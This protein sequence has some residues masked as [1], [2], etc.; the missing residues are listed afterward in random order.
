MSPL[1]LSIIIPCL[2]EAENIFKT[3]SH[4]Q[5]LRRRGHEVILSDGGSLDDTLK[6]SQS[7]VD[8]CISS[9]AGRAIQM[10]SGA[11]I[12]NGDILCFLHADTIAPENIDQ[13]ILNSMQ[14]TASINQIS[15]GFFSIR[16]SSTRWPFRVIEWFINQ[17][18]CIS[19]IATGDQG[20]FIYKNLFNNIS[21]FAKITLMEDIN[22]SKR[23]KKISRP[24]CIKNNTLI[25]SSR[26]WEKHGIIRTVVLMWKLRLAYFLGINA[27]T[28]AKVYH[29]HEKNK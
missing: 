24:I 13:L 2:N 15:W 16:L 11:K 9:A 14:N 23:L 20:I 29:S 5:S 22:F 3:L 21:G 26:R 27:N 4:L 25:T 19:H 10:N 6:L 12:A 1:K 28:L 8:H 17:R 7:L 18:S